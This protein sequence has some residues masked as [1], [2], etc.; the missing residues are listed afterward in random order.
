MVNNKK[1]KKGKANKLIKRQEQEYKTMI[2]ELQQFSLE[3]PES[4]A[5]RILPESMRVQ[6]KCKPCLEDL[7]FEPLDK[8]TYERLF[9]HTKTKN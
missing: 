5:A 4:D 9:K 6:P 2:K 8:E 7:G 1:L 3:H